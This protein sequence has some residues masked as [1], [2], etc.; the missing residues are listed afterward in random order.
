MHDCY[1]SL[2]LKDSTRRSFK[3]NIY[4]Y[5]AILG[6]HFSSALECWSYLDKMSIRN[7]PIFT[8]DSYVLLFRKQSYENAH[9]DWLIKN[10]VSI[11]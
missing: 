6:C 9:A 2:C 8:E 4:Q 1:R 3:R 7:C 11:N 10:R 5:E